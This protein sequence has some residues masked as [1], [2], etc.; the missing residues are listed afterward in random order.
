LLLQARSGKETMWKGRFGT[1]E[2]IVMED[3]A[4]HF[5]IHKKELDKFSP[6]QSVC[7]SARLSVYFHFFVDHF[8]F[9]N[10]NV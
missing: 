5:Y 4:P 8:E 3:A 9:I 2:L 1:T 10:I 6:G 7:L